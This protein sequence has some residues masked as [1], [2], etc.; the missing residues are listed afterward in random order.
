MNIDAIYSEKTPW[1]VDH[2]PLSLVPVAV[3]LCDGGGGDYKITEGSY[4]LLPISSSRR[5][6]QITHECA[7]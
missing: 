7:D 1:K 2:G 3:P 6:S 4:C 5:C